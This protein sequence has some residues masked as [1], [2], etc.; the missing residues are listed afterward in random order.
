MKQVNCY[1]CDSSNATV[2]VRQS[3]P[4]K[5]L[6]LIDP[7]YNQDVRSVVVCSQCGLVYRQPQIDEADA[8]KLY[9]HFRDHSVLSEPPDQ[10][11][12]RI[13]TLADEQSENYAKL[14]WLASHI[15]EFLG[16][17][18]NRVL[19]IGCGGGVFLHKFKEWYPGWDC[20]GIEP[21][22][23]FA[24]LARRS[25]AESSGRYVPVGHL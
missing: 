22:P 14:S 3:F 12:D 11:F 15:G 7:A 2:V 8:R 17:Q 16:T 23:Q 1:V 6:T 21:T 25:G 9:E 10:Y 20:F 18:G 5:Y 13:S 4:D 24:D 19:D